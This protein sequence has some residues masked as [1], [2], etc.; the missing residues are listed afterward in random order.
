M[1]QLRSRPLV[2]GERSHR[3]HTS[4]ATHW[5]TSTPSAP[6]PGWAHQAFSRA[7]ANQLDEAVCAAKAPFQVAEA[8]NVRSEGRL[9]VPDIV[10]ADDSAVDWD[11]TV[12]PVEAVL[13]L[14]EIVSPFNKPQDRVF[15]PALYAQANVPAYWRVELEPS[16]HVI[17]HELSGNAYQE[18]GILKGQQTTTVAGAFTAEVDLDRVRARFRP[19]DACD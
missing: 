5:T 16:P 8:V 14:V 10:I 11:T 9:F 17:V 7:L 6:A 2:D 4:D 1:D 15:K 19:T 18:V 13:L 3:A 12:V